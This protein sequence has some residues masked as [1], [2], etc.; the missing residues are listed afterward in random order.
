[1]WLTGSGAVNAVAW[2]ALTM[3]I[4]A[5]RVSV[6]TSIVYSY[7]LFSVLLARLMLSD[8]ENLTGRVVA[9]CVLIVLGVVLVSLLG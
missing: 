8:A 5:G 9:G 1:L 3:S 2:I 6:M 7:P 4:T